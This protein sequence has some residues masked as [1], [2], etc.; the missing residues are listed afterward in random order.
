LF[1]IHCSLLIPNYYPKSNPPQRLGG[2]YL[3]RFPRS[4]HTAHQRD[5]YS[6][7]KYHQ[8]KHGRNPYFK[9]D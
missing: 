3:N 9:R 7:G 4:R 1:I 6:G 2:L 8:Q 5:E